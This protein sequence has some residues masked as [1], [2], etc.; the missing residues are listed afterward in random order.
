MRGRCMHVCVCA[1]N[2]IV[3]AFIHMSKCQSDSTLSSKINEFSQECTKLNFDFNRAT[4]VRCFASI[5][6]MQVAMACDTIF[7]TI[8][9]WRVSI[10]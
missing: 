3:L 5:E 6:F 2:I 8:D 1:P 4:T 10:H 7:L 9:L